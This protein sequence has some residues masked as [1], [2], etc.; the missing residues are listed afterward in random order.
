MT[1]DK[2]RR[3]TAISISGVIALSGCATASKDLTSSYVSP[4]QYQGYS[5][6]QV[7]TESMRVQRRV[8]EL[9]GRL[10]Q[11]ASND[12]A[13]TTAGIVLFW[14]ALFF[15][16]GTKNQEAEYS[17]LKGE[18]DALHQ[19]SIAKNCFAEN[20]AVAP[21]IAKTNEIPIVST[22]TLPVSSGQDG[23]KPLPSVAQF[24]PAPFNIGG[25][26][27]L[28][29]GSQL[30]LVGQTTTYSTGMSSG[31]PLGNVVLVD[32]REGKFFASIEMQANLQQGNMSGWTDEPCKRENFLWKRSTG[33]AFENINCASINH[34]TNFY[35]SP[36]GVHQQY[37][38][39]FKQIGLEVPPTVINIT[40][41]RHHNQGRRLIYRINLNPEVFGI[42]RDAETV[43][44]A[45][46]WHKS[47]IDKDPKKVVF[48]A[49]LT[50]WA[51]DVQD[52][53][54]SAFE[55]N[56]SAFVGLMPFKMYF[57]APSMLSQSN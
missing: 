43:W 29:L 34:V 47:F 49:H 54:D 30:G 44:G 52:R 7:A 22:A 40:F 35:A 18:Y 46:S 39:Q 28:D 11:A 21:A 41:T 8:Q 32:I 12:A 17:R 26:P 57:N 9:G 45:N 14:P 27:I 2:I 1:P 38:G 50:K 20:S 5:C 25:Y 4:Y 42:A 13:I 19:A 10:D 33:R 31:L 23:A 53:M 15:L 51:E 24:E 55:K 6:Q 37:L 16:G 48:I 3:S 36:T 56:S